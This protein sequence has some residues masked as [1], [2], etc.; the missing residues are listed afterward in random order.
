MNGGEKWKGFSE[1]PPSQIFSH[2]PPSQ[3]PQQSEQHSQSPR[4]WLPYPISWN[5]SSPYRLGTPCGRCC[6]SLI[7]GGPCK[8][9][10]RAEPMAEEG[11]RR[12]LS[13]ERQCP[14]SFRANKLERMCISSKL[15]RTAPASGPGTH[16][17]EL[18]GSCLLALPA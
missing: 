17:A 6:S 2:R 14:P 16:S 10:G 9:N 7:K 15:P 1:A 4:L 13:E 3:P 18:V 12:G 11:G 8:L 5:C